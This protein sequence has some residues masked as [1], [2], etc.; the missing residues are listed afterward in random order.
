MSLLQ[1][2]QSDL[3]IAS[4]LMSTGALGT[5]Q[6]HSHAFFFYIIFIFFILGSFFFSLVVSVGKC[7]VYMMCVC[8]CVCVC[9]AYTNVLFFSIVFI[10]TFSNK[11]LQQSPYFLLVGSSLLD[12]FSNFI[13]CKHCRHIFRF[14]LNLS[15]GT[16]TPECEVTET[17]VN[18]VTAANTM[19]NR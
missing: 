13:E 11:S 2:G 9:N 12:R 3:E 8:M 7:M 14:S 6:L 1:I 17:E 4:F 16:A 15:C 5:A 19:T 10:L 18:M